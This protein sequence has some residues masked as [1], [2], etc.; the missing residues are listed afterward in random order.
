LGH[1]GF[2]FDLAA[3]PFIGVASAGQ[4]RDLFSVSLVQA[5]NLFLAL[6]TIAVEESTPT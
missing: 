4:L 2:E 1:G 5:E 6:L 3:Q